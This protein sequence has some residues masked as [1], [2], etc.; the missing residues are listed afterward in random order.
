MMKKTL[1]IIFFAGVAVIVALF[2]LSVTGIIENNGE[3]T[4]GFPYKNAYTSFLLAMALVYLVITD[5]KVTPLGLAGYACL[6]GFVLWIGGKTDFVLLLVLTAVLALKYFNKLRDGKV[7]KSILSGVRFAFPAVCA[8]NYI[9]VL[10]YR[11]L[12]GF[13]L[14]APGMKTFGDRLYFARL[15]FEEYPLT[16]FGTYIPFTG[17]FEDKV[18]D[19]FFVLD[20]AYVKYIFGYGIVPFIA[21]MT[22]LTALMFCLYG[23]KRY[24]QMF[25]LA[26]YSV[27]LAMNGLAIYLVLIIVFVIACSLSGKENI[28]DLLPSRRTVLIWLGS[29]IAAVMAVWGAGSLVR[30]DSKSADVITVDLYV[31]NQSADIL[32]QLDGALE[33][34]QED[35]PDVQTVQRDRIRDYDITAL[36]VMGSD[37]IPDVFIADCR[38]GR[39]LAG[40]GLVVDLTGAAADEGTFTYGDRVCAFPAL[41]QSYSVIIYDP[42]SWHEGDPVGYASDSEFTAADCYL[43]PLLGDDW[44]RD[45]LDHMVAADGEASFTDSEMIGRIGRMDQM[46]SGDTAYGSYSEL[47]QAFIEGECPAVVLYGDYVY[48]FLDELEASAPEL[49]E[50]TEFACMAEGVIPAGYE[51]GVFVRAGM[52]EQ[53]T[54]ECIELASLL[55]SSVIPESDEVHARLYD[56]ADNCEH[57]RLLTQYFTYNYWHFVSNELYYIRSIRDRSIEARVDELQRFYE[58]YYFT[59]YQ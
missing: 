15:A 20:S 55:A 27:D 9:L 2:L 59:D 34:W 53:K 46:I 32:A 50:R 5:G 56:L 57:T 24:V 3:E 49:Y 39:I 23:G 8:V 25:A 29:F 17:S 37:H 12:N 22:A 10:S 28:R 19:L 14:A 45:W 6:T 36:A 11:V 7:K 43:S 47:T 4:F 41:R 35:H 13:W 58:L 40:E 33:Q 51:Y 26:L 30:S 18:T 54:S 1:K 38:L 42:L 52:D 16:L 21:V 44:G 31:T 48:A